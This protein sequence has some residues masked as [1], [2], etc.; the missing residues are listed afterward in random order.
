M[1]RAIS[2]LAPNWFAFYQAVIDALARSLSINIQL[3]QGECDPLD[4]PL[5][6]Q[7]QLDLAFICGLPFIR[8]HRVNPRQLQVLAV[9]ILSASRYVDRPIYF[10]DVVVN[11]ASDITCF[12]DLANKSFC[13]NDR[14]SNSGYNL[15]RCYLLKNGYSSNFLSPCIESGSHLQSLRWVIEGQSDWATIDSTV[16]EQAL[17]DHPEWANQIKVIAAIGPSPMPPI[18][19]ATRLGAVM[20]QKCELLYCILTQLC[21]LQW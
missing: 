15:V 10:S 17:R 14:G 20:L 4:D 5:L 9:P 7:D 6:L 16:L 18:V 12:S 3:Q 19:V 1:L 8:H 13:Y 2:Y 11:A 21:R